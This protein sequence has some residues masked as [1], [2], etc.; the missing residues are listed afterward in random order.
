MEFVRAMGRDAFHARIHGLPFWVLVIGNIA[1]GVLFRHG[2]DAFVRNGKGC[3]DRK[4]LW[5]M[6]CVY[7]YHIN[8]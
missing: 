3:S 4:P 2:N 1:N 5:E 6:G 8:V 7:I